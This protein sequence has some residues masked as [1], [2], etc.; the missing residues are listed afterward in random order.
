MRGCSWIGMVAVWALLLYIVG[1]DDDFFSEEALQAARSQIAPFPSCRNNEQATTLFKAGRG[2]QHKKENMRK[3][4]HGAIDT[5]GGFA[6]AGVSILMGNP[7][8]VIAG[9]ISVIKG[10]VGL[11]G[12]LFGFNT[13]PPPPTVRPEHIQAYQ[14]QMELLNMVGQ[15]QST[16]NVIDQKLQ[17]S[18]GSAMNAVEATFQKLQFADD[19]QKYLRDVEFVAE[20]VWVDIRS[21]SKQPLVNGYAVFC[22]R[23]AKTDVKVAL[24]NFEML[25][26]TS[27][28]SSYSA[29]YKNR[30]ITDAAA[31]QFLN[32]LTQVT[33][34]L[35]TA[36]TICGESTKIPSLL[37]E[38]VKPTINSIALNLVQME[39]GR[40]RIIHEHLSSFS[41][42]VG[43]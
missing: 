20:S 14:E 36:Q 24:E 17:E 18:T 25:L 15:I 38:R 9:G 39:N 26:N 40:V 19:Y 7:I 43:F 29:A 16:V 3:I 35:L 8:G 23:C 41:G 34:M 27:L 12:G 22:H 2:K 42:L 32:R 21:V 30:Q 11:F 4:V 1:G 33:M 13:P 10:V 28:V 37:I 6:T 31:S 5:L